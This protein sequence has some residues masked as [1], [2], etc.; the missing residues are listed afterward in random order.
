MRTIWVLIA[1]SVLSTVI[2]FKVP[3]A[4]ASLENMEILNLFNNALEDVPV[5]LSSMP[6]LRILNL[7][8]N[9]LTK[10]P[11]GF[12]SFASIEVRINIC[13]YRRP[14]YKEWKPNYFSLE[15]FCY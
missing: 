3:P 7:G 6:K 5:S 9:K 4:I 2:L 1:V 13:H 10:L 15:M 12:G 8:V 14:D 11:R